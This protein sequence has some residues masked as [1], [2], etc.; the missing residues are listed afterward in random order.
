MIGEYMSVNEIAKKWNLT[1]RRVQRMC[2]EGKIE[3]SVKFG[4]SWAIPKSVD[5]PTDLRLTTGEWI[6]YRKYKKQ[7]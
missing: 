4:R 5:K 7:K 1:P 3:G 6:D 2:A